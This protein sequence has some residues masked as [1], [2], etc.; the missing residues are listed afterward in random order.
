MTCHP[1]KRKLVNIA[2]IVLVA[3]LLWSLASNKFPE[4]YKKYIIWL[5]YFLAFY[6]LFLLCFS[7]VTPVIIIKEDYNPD[8]DAKYNVHHLRIYDSYPG[9]DLPNITIKKGDIVAWI[10]IG[11]TSHT[12]SDVN[13][14]FNSG[15][16]KPGEN[17]SVM[18]VLPGVYNYQ[19]LHH[20]GWQKGSVT[21]I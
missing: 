13:G 17:Y 8:I 11:E 18:F 15:Y 4:N 6:H 16:L 1:L 7:S 2:H 10:N 21:V 5:A 3:P 14:Q 12:I 20:R 9:H 19:C